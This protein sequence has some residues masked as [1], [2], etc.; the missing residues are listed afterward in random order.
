MEH[1]VD[2]AEHLARAGKRRGQVAAHADRLAAL[3]GEDESGGGHRG[4]HGKG[5]DGRRKG[6][7]RI[8]PDPGS[9]NS[10]R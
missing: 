7:P 8:A 10:T 1:L 5:W 2:L 3:A 6:G 9:V 4:I